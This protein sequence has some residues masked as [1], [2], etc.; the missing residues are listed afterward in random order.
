VRVIIDLPF[1][2]PALLLVWDEKAELDTLHN[3]GHVSNLFFPAKII[4][5]ARFSD[6]F[7]YMQNSKD[8]SKKS[9]RESRVNK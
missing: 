4:V 7:L 2:K 5:Y 1:D 3:I 8:S 6:I 9:Y